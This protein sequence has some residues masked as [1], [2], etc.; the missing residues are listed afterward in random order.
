MSAR[1]DAQ[2]LPS[3]APTVLLPALTSLVG[4]ALVLV[5]LAMD[6]GEDV[7]ARV[8]GTDRTAGQAQAPADE[9]WSG[10]LETSDGTAADL[11][12]AWPQFRGPARDGISRETV[13]LARQWGPQ[14][15]PVL[16]SLE[17]GEGYA[18]PAIRNGRVYLL[19][20]DRPN[21]A[22]ALRCL[23]LADGREIWRYSYPVKVKRNH[24]MSRTIPAVTDDYVVSLGPKCHVVCLDAKS[25]RFR[26]SIDLVK[27]YGTKV[28]LWYAG[29][30]PL[31]DG[32]RAI[33]AP[34]GSSL[35]VAV[36]CK[37]GQVVWK[38]PNPSRW[39]MSH[40]SIAPMTWNGR[41]TYVY[42]AHGGVVGVA[43]DSGELLWQTS[44]WKISIATISSA[45]PLGGDRVFLSGGYG[46][47]SM[48]LRLQGANGA[49]RAESVF[50]LKPEVF[51]STQQTPL[52]YGGHVYGVRPDGEMV[53]LDL[54][55]LEG[56]TLWSSGAE[57]RFGIGPYLIA[58]GLIFVMDDRGRLTLLEATPAGYRQLAAARVL[59]GRESWGPLAL[60][61]GRLIARDL[62]RMVC[63]DVRAK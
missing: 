25:G 33:L 13:R 1:T 61:G 5:W 26:W 3:K 45:L 38:T 41:R 55:D 56:R 6:L 16:W 39:A 19:D 29:Q 37:T 57:H 42:C 35:L 14:G 54:L 4:I 36:D 59:D 9:P 18:A 11:P 7:A 2:P 31:I 49:A 24:G 8:P 22:D 21:Q 27:D 47:G 20:Y 32:D 52:L 48:V 10:K 28:P 17:V 51:G 34:G 63:L 44:A 62:T 43:A 23:S 46:A 58:D 15:P 53:C 12:G 60:A 50:R 40:A 30:C